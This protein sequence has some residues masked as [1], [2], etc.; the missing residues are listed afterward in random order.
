MGIVN[1]TPDSFS[2][3][4][5]HFAAEEALAGGRRMIADGADIL[6][7]GGES[8]RPGHVAVSAE[9]EWRRIEPVFRGLADAPDARPPIS[10]DTWKAEVALRA[11]EAGASIVNDVWGFQRDPDIAAVTAASGAGAILM[12]NREAIDP[13]LD[14]VDDIMRFLERSLTI[15]SRAGLPGDRIAVDPGIGFGKTYDQSFEALRSLSRLREFGC[16]ILLGLSRKG[17]IGSLSKPPSPTGQRLGGT[18]A[19]N[20]LGALAGADIIRVHDVAPNLQAMRLI[21]RVGAAA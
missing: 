5:V 7:I 13:A 20:V 19:G 11:L 14:I 18:I 17:F 21:Q 15:A 8:T 1:I 16:A 10:V 4:G 9:E 6:D 2:D 12:H 3:G